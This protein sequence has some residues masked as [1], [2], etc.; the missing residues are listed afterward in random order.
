MS[1]FLYNDKQ[2][3]IILIPKD[4]VIDHLYYFDSRLPTKQDIKNTK[5]P[6]V[7]T[8]FKSRTVEEG[9]DQIKRDIS[10]IDNK[11]PLYDAYIKNLLLISRE[12]VYSKVIYQYFRFPDRHLINILKERKKELDPEIKELSKKNPKIK[13]EREYLGKKLRFR[14]YGDNL[15]IFDKLHYQQKNKEILLIREHQKLRLMLQ[16]LSYF[17]LEILHGTYLKVFYY[18]ANEVGKNLT[19][20]IKPSFT[21]HLSHIK[22]YYSRTELINIAL[23][24]ELIDPSNIYYDQDKIM[25]LCNIVKQNDISYKT[26]TDHQEYIVKNNGIGILQYYSLQGSYFI[27]RYLR[28]LHNEY[29]NEII[30]QVV[31]S[32]W[33][34]INN[35]PKFDKSYILYRFVQDDTYLKTLSIGDTFIDKGFVSTTRDPF[36]K[37]EV[38]KFGFI[39]IKI[40]IPPEAG[41]GLCIETISNFPEEQEIILSPQSILRLDKKD[42][43]AIYYHT[44]DNFGSRVQT[45]YEFTYKGKNPIQLPNKIELNIGQTIDFLKI[46]KVKT[47]TIEER[48][49]IFIKNYVNQNNQFETS[50][51]TVIAEW[52]DSTNAYKTFYAATTNNGFSLYTIIN[53]YIEFFIEIGEN[54]KQSYMYVNYYFRYS[55]VNRK[56]SIDDDDLLDFI[57]RLAYH[58][59]IYYVTI[60]AEYQSCDIDMDNKLLYGG[61]YCVDFY[62][63]FK[64]KTKRFNNVDKTELT[65]KFNYYELDR[66]RNADPL[67]ILSKEDRDEIYQIYIEGY[68]KSFGEDKHNIVDF[69]I[70]IAE[71]RCI[72]LNQLVE[73]M[74]RIYTIDNPFDNDF[75]SFDPFA[76]LYNKNLISEYSITSRPRSSSTSKNAYRLDYNYHDK[77]GRSQSPRSDASSRS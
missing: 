16:F 18:Y 63:Y 52:Y 53:S 65:P 17:N 20:C 25:K 1:Y 69:Y 71:N 72:N 39:L 43:D 30:N 31:I 59:D 29:N 32:L 12:K 45:R 33:K 48:I 35:A 50:I 58:F 22:P 41:V 73:K 74:T 76:H 77:K 7:Q 26:I 42:D 4:E 36:Y 10:K 55:T 34:L 23:N 49:D 44:D 2:E 46:P 70:W 21:P 6:K 38:Y 13:Q 66:L 68:R 28:C 5:N 37:S 24:F 56:K 47:E 9:I 64:N 57:S 67:L 27:N 62:N 14:H 19:F 8:F 40:K 60:Y 54:N 3:D 75:Y 11:V 51:G 61:N 15:D